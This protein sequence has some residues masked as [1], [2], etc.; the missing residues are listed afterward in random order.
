MIRSKN[1]NGKKNGNVRG[2]VVVVTGAARGIGAALAR[3]L[4]D[5][6]ATVALLGLEPTELAASA[7]ACGDR[8]AAWPVDVT[9]STR[10]A[11]VAKQVVDRFGR[12]DVVVANAG[13][14]QGGTLLSSDPAAFDRVINVN[15]LG[16]VRTARAFLP[17]LVASKGYFL[18]IASLA[19]IIHSPMIGAYCAS[20]AGVEAFA[21]S[22]RIEALHHGV[23]VGVA[24]L[25]FTDTDMVRGTD[26][27][28][29]LRDMRATAPYPINRTYP[30]A[31]TVDRIAAGISQ[32]APFV[33]AQPWIRI[34][35]VTRGLMPSLSARF[36]GVG[37]AEAESALFEA[38]TDATLPVGAGGSA[39]WSSAKR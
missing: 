33:Y 36:G 11:E 21:N 8:A 28:T 12:I 31:P 25:S 17:N 19:A 22:L 23:A 13:I 5:R 30:L 35:A 38:G 9:D 6:G 14:G 16:S 10:L 24:Y 37:V 27:V 32:R 1:G 2:Q 26:A 20:K 29:A 39:D 34:A 15:L 3:Q 7:A 4:A 18:Q